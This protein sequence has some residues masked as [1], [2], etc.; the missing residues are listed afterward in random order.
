MLNR[1]ANSDELS[2]QYLGRAVLLDIFLLNFLKLICRKAYGAKV[3]QH[4]SLQ[5]VSGSCGSHYKAVGISVWYCEYYSKREQYWLLL[6]LNVVLLTQLRCCGLVC[7]FGL[8]FVPPKQ[9][10]IIKLYQASLTA[11]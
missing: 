5:L 2:E 9:T 11:K 10:M 1:K 8:F 6:V 4:Q 7:L 3:L